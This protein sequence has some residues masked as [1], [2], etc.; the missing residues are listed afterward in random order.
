MAAA[1]EL[2]TEF[3]IELEEADER[4]KGL[5]F[6]GGFPKSGGTF[7]GASYSK[8]CSIWGPYWGPPI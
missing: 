3:E 7:F 5:G 1:V 8:D 6:F 2:G 4:F